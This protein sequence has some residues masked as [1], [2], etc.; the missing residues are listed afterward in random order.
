M[1]LKVF[2]SN[3]HFTLSVSLII[4]VF[5]YTLMI[6]VRNLMSIRNIDYSAILLLKTVAYNYLLFS[7]FKILLKVNLV[8][9]LFNSFTYIFQLD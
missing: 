2:L 1:N 6:F 3:H 4:N 7:Q 5:A 9:T 8:K